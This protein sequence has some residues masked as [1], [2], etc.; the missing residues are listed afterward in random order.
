MKRFGWAVGLGAFIAAGQAWAAGT[1]LPTGQT[2]TPTAAPGA[3]FAALNPGLPDHPRYAAGEA[4][5]SAVS[6]DGNT[7]LVLTAG[8]N[9]LNYPS[10]P[11]AGQPEPSASNQYVFVYDIS[12]AHAGAPLLRQVLPVANSFSG[13]VWAPDGTRFYV[14]GGVSDAVFTF[15]SSGGSWAL[16]ATTAL[17]HTS[18]A[19]NLPAYAQILGAFLGNGI[20]ILQA[21][22]AGGLAITPDGTRLLVTNLGNDSVSLIDTTQNT[23]LWEYD[24]RPYLNTPALSGT[25][26]GEVP[27]GVAIAG[28][29]AT[30]YTAFVSSLRDH[31]IDAFPL[32]DIPPDTGTIFRIPVTGNPNN[33]VL[34]PDQGRLYVAEDNADFIGIIDTARLALAREIPVTPAA[35]RRGSFTGR[36]PNGLAVSRDGNTLYVSLGGANAISVIPVN[37]TNALKPQG[38]IPTGWY[39]NAVSVSADGRTLYAANGRSVPG[40]NPLYRTAAANQY[41]LQLE[42]AGLLALPV[43]NAGELA[44][45]TADVVANNN[46]AYQESPAD[47]ALM[48]K[49]RAKIKHV[50]YIIKENRTFDQILGDLGNGSAG[51]PSLTEYGVQVTP[52]LHAIAGNFVTLDHFFDS[53]EVSGDGWPWSTEARESDFGVKTIPPNYAN[54]GFQNDSEGLNR[55]INVGLPLAGREASYPVVNGIGNLYDVLS[56]A[57]PGGTANLLPGLNNDFATDGPFGTPHGEGYLWDQALRAGLSVRNYGFFIDLVRYNIP[58][59]LG[60]VP[61]LQN[62]AA[63]GTQVAWPANPTLAPYTDIYYRGF[64]NA[65][66]DVWRVQEW[67]REFAGYV[68]NGN[69]PA[70]SLVRLMHDHTGSFSSAVAGINTPTLQTAD[71]DWAVGL[72]AQAVARSPYAANT[73]IFVLEDDAQDGPDHIDAHRSTAYVIGPYVKQNAVVSQ[74]YTTVNMVRT[75]EELLGVGYLNLNDATQGPMTQVFDLNQASW[76]FTAQPSGVL[77]GTGLLNG[78]H[79]RFAPGAAPREAHD[80]AWWAEKTKG[81]DWSREDRVPADRYNRIMWEGLKPG[82]PYPGDAR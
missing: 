63:S 38:L 18:Y 65:F 75:I 60:G 41:I 54:R 76:S 12:G 45:L 56:S 42:G 44:T 11:N 49:L 22:E 31:E 82:V 7:L 73:I 29:A 19:R 59:F 72:L 61:L 71:N 4:I 9:L 33:M 20:G 1:L 67:F 8:Y 36:A 27:Y 16:T 69:L 10:G 15:A 14:A 6:P 74:T 30:G 23:V 57:F 81:F 17:G 28:S 48:A 53:G 52:N 3:V 79:V 62:P 78:Q 55:I 40:P 39:P 13:L 66:P 5:S 2:I 25:A 80:A 26:G 50:I 24:L 51:D 34:S 64:D 77:Q 37:G 43:P 46:V 35:A 58:T 47:K 21:A 70:L 32:R 68:S